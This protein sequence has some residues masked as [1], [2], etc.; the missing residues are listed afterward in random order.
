MPKEELEFDRMKKLSDDTFDHVKEL[1]KQEVASHVI[2]RLT[3]IG[4]AAMTLVG[5]LSYFGAQEIIKRGVENSTILVKQQGEAMQANFDKRIVEQVDKK[6]EVMES[7]MQQARIDVTEVR[8]IAEVYQDDFQDSRRKMLTWIED[9][10]K[11]AENLEQQERQFNELSIK[12]EHATNQLIKAQELNSLYILPAAGL[13]SRIEVARTSLAVDSKNDSATNQH[14]QLVLIRSVEQLGN[15]EFRDEEKDLKIVVIKFLTKLLVKSPPA[16]HASPDKVSSD[17]DLFRQVRTQAIYALR[18]L[19]SNPPERW[20][21]VE[22]L[23]FILGDPD[24]YLQ[25]DAAARGLQVLADEVLLSTLQENEKRNQMVVKKALTELVN[26]GMDDKDEEVQRD[27]K[28]TLREI[29]RTRAFYEFELDKNLGGFYSGLNPDL[30]TSLVC[31]LY[32]QESEKRERAAEV[33]A[34][35]GESGQSFWRTVLI[36]LVKWDSDMLDM[37]DENNQMIQCAEQLQKSV[38]ELQ[39]PVEELL[40]KPDEKVRIIA[41]NA[42]IENNP[43]VAIRTFESL[44]QQDTLTKNKKW[45]IAQKRLVRK[46]VSE[47]N[48]KKKSSFEAGRWDQTE[49][50]LLKI[51]KID[52]HDGHLQELVELYQIAGKYEKAKKQTEGLRR[53]TSKNSELTLYSFFDAVTASLSGEFNQKNKDRLCLAAKAAPVSGWRFSIFQRFIDENNPEFSSEI[54][55]FVMIAK[56]GQCV[57]NNA[58]N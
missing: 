20:S 1:Y 33:A 51:Q 58:S 29:V 22:H 11:H 12:T 53:S 23:T 40:K 14:E 52:P 28:E 42:L 57:T 19:S 56:T 41:A 27:A 43:T 17:E 18:R 15:R 54:G 46:R 9:L 6:L 3:A 39:K 38:E 24:K 31:Q 44:N 16:E 34:I 4:T 47:L 32:H 30:R 35:L 26:A 48:R 21:A 45:K 13:M 25:R 10:G 2:R 7:T 36:N 8:T 49:E 50:I 55:D 37:T 5:I